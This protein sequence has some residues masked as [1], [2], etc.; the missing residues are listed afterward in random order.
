M[1]TAILPLKYN[2]FLL[3]AQYSQLILIAMIRATIVQTDI[4]KQHFS[5][6]I[7]PNYFISDF[8]IFSLPT[9]YISSFKIVFQISSS[10]VP[11][12]SRENYKISDFIIIYPYSIVAAILLQCSVLYRYPRFLLIVF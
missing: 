12:I 2:M 1:Q 4:V 10:S 6:P 7:L 9:F 5:I 8:L 11:K 3:C